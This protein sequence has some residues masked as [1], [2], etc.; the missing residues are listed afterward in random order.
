LLLGTE[1]PKASWSLEGTDGIVSVDV[2]AHLASNDVTL[3]R[4]A[5][6]G[7][8][9]IARLPTITCFEDERKGRLARVLPDYACGEAGVYAV[10]PSG[11]HLSP[12][13]RAFVEVAAL[14]VARVE[15]PS[16]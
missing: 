2:E 9:G 10:F 6:V 15:L 4:S 3:L 11:T 14:V 5:A 12:K 8:R 7:G 13:V 1:R 16:G